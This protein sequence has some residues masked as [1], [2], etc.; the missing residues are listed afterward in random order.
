MTNAAC[1]GCLP[2]SGYRQLDAV[3]F[4]S[5]K[6]IDVSP[7][8]Y[9]YWLE[10]PLDETDAMRVG[11]A[12]HT[13]ALEPGKFQRRFAIWEGTR[14]GKAWKEFETASVASGKTILTATQVDPVRAMAAALL[15]KPDNLSLLTGGQ[16]ELSITWTE[17]T[18]GI[19][20]KCRVDHLTDEY[21]D[22]LKSTKSIDAFKF[23]RA[24]GD[25]L[26][27][28]QSAIY[29]D[30]AES[31]DGKLRKC[32][33]LA[34]EKSQPHESAV[35]ELDEELLD[36]G[37]TKWLEWL[38]TLAHCR[39]TNRWPQRYELPQKLQLAPWQTAHEDDDLSDLG[40]E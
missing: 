18:T 38:E 34:V 17:R 32:R 29:R 5:L 31:L 26:Y 33:L 19:K 7:Y 3:N 2:F 9:R 16:R 23:G 1:Y 30:A 14:R 20:C 13:L 22:D 24:A 4:S 6:W 21:L 11:S 28:V 12:L 25:Y 40:L 10:H 27:C 8:T 15:A 39:E 36:E 37:H 35:Y